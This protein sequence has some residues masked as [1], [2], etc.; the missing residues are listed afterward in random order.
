MASCCVP[1]FGG[2]WEA[3]VKSVKKHLKYSLQTSLLTFQE[4]TTILQVAVNSRP[5]LPLDTFPENGVHPL[6]QSHILMGKSTVSLLI[7]IPL[8]QDSGMRR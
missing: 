3:A 2:L 8:P 6:T 4:L 7:E 1:N 5:L